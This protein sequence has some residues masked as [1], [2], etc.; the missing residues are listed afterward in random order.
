MNALSQLLH[1]QYEGTSS[2]HLDHL[3]VSKTF[4]NLKIT[5]AK[6]RQVFA[7]LGRSL[8]G[9]C[10]HAS[11][12]VFP[13]L[14]QGVWCHG[15]VHLFT[16]CFLYVSVPVTRSPWRLAIMPT[17]PLHNTICPHLQGSAHAVQTTATMATD[18]QPAI[19][20][21]LASVLQMSILVGVLC[22]WWRN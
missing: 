22:R 17:G 6:Q 5:D 3:G 18:T 1:F 11:A 10:T 14:L 7:F 9:C 12:V 21:V 20:H 8:T 2:E 15:T 4:F 19:V 16:T 13:L